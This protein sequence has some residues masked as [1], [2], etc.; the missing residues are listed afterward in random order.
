MQQENDISALDKMI[1]DRPDQEICKLKSLSIQ[2][3]DFNTNHIS[4]GKDCKYS[5]L[6]KITSQ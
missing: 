6:E 5:D 1:T 3:K 2:H 4:Y